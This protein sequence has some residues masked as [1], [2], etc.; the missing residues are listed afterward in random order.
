[1][2]IRELIEM[3]KKFDTMHGWVPDKNEFTSVLN[4]I[5][6]DIIGIVGELGEFSNIIKKINL[7]SDSN[8]TEAANLKFENER[9]NLAE[10]IID[11][12]IYLMRIMDC[13][14]I[15]VESEYIEKLQFNRDKF[16]GF[17]N[18]E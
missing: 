9:E 1:M 5:N 13:L 17:K 7:L 8:N 3:Q 15:D 2:D 11:V 12:F 16:K 14:N 6:K 18:D 10:E 4:T